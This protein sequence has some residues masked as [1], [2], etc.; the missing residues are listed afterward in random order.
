MSALAAAFAE[1]GHHRPHVGVSGP[2]CRRRPRH[3][4]KPICREQSASRLNVSIIESRRVAGKLVHEHIAALGSIEVPPTIGARIIFWK[5][6]HE[7][8]G[9]LG[10]RIDPAT[11]ARLKSAVHERI[12]IPTPDGPPSVIVKAW[13]CIRRFALLVVHDRGRDRVEPM[14]SS[15]KSDAKALTRGRT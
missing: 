11:Q 10:N 15:P 5:R 12:P 6:M 13:P 9:K 4:K 2:R 1:S 8:L 3:R 14:G 7:R